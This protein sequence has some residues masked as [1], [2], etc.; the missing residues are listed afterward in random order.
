[1]VYKRNGSPCQASCTQTA[2]ELCLNNITSTM[3][4]CF[5]ESGYVMESGNC[6]LP[7][8]CGC[9]VSDGSYFKVFKFSCCLYFSLVSIDITF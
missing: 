9:K 1:M 7:S 5:C 6:I 4:G 8:E 3:E 2:E